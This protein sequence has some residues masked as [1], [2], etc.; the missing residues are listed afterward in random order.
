VAPT[1]TELEV[2]LSRPGILVLAD[3]CFPGWEVTVDGERQDPLCA[4]YLV[5]GVELEE[6]HHLVRFSYRPVSVRWGALASGGAAIVVL[7]IFGRAALGRARHGLPR[8]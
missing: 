1:R 8:V 3:S 6:G 4:N 2:E 5:R 7:A